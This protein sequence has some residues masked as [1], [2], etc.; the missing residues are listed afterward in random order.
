MDM[1]VHVL[2]SRENHDVIYTMTLPI[3]K[4]DIVKAR[5][6]FVV[7][8]EMLQMLLMIP[9]SI[10]HQNVNAMGNEAGMD[11]NIVL[12]AEVQYQYGQKPQ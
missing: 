2:S 3:A 10:L 4:S 5:I 12:L 7:I 6:S 11:A 9:F 1:F 8:L